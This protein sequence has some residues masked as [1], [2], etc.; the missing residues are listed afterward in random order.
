VGV[1]AIAYAICLRAGVYY[2]EKVQKIK[3]KKHGYKE[4]SFIRT[5]RDIL[6]E[7][8]KKSATVMTQLKEVVSRFILIIDRW[9]KRQIKN[10][11]IK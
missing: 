3:I 9:N 10:S 2:N 1:V 5:G 11:L 6:I 4:K 8:L 7:L